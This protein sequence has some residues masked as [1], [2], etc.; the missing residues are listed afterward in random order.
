[1]KAGHPHNVIR[2]KMPHSFSFASN[3]DGGG[4]LSR[5]TSPRLL[6]LFCGISA[7]AF[8]S[9]GIALSGFRSAVVVR[10]ML[11]LPGN[12]LLQ[13]FVA[14]TLPLTV[15]HATLTGSHM[16]LSCY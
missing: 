8:V 9:L 11:C 4:S 14:L 7:G 6:P 12:L 10:W 15:L 13:A 3:G 5:M 16:Q 2:I 1:M